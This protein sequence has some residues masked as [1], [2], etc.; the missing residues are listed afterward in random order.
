MVDVAA[1]DGWR[2]LLLEGQGS[3]SVPSVEYRRKGQYCGGTGSASER[4][5]C[6]LRKGETLLGK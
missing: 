5:A 2:M 4:V 1:F 6:L 3:R